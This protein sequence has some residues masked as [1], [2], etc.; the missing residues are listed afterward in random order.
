MYMGWFARFYCAAGLDVADFGYLI[1]FLYLR[2]NRMF[3][4]SPKHAARGIG[5]RQTN[6]SNGTEPTRHAVLMNG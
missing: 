6:R 4:G 2:Q 3:T 5:I 1:S